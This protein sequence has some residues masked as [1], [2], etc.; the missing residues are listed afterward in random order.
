MR[1]TTRRLSKHLSR[2][3]PRWRWSRH[4]GTDYRGE[5]GRASPHRE[6]PK[7]APDAALR[8]ILERRRVKIGQMAGRSVIGP[9]EANLH[10]A[11][12]LDDELLDRSWIV[13]CGYRRAE[14]ACRPVLVEPDP[15]VG[16]G[17]PHQVGG[18]VIGDDEGPE[19]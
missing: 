4:G 15:A 13:S 16:R 14:P 1:T 6:V 3:C 11:G 8:W 18:F 19:L 17:H 7:R 10:S 5:R 12:P 2:T 9:A